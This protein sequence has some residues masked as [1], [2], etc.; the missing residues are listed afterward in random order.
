MT[1]INYEK[2]YIYLLKSINF[3]QNKIGMKLL[4]EPNENNINV[5][6]NYSGINEDRIVFE[7]II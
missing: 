2:D 5:V 3:H 4:G 7:K 1:S 6:K